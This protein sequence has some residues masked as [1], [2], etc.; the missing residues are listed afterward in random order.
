M[1]IHWPTMDEASSRF[2]NTFFAGLTAIGLIAGGLYTLWQYLTQYKLQVTVATQSARVP[3]DSKRLDL[4]LQAS[5]DA[6][7]IAT[8]SD[9]KAKEQAIE[10][11]WRL[12][13]GPLGIV[14]DQ[15]IAA[16]LT[17]F[18]NCLKEPCK[19]QPLTTLAYAIAQKCRTAVSK[20]FSLS[21]HEVPEGRSQS[22]YNAA[23]R[24]E[25]EDQQ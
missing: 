22:R 7:S 14:E 25:E 10:D 19:T 20:S 2:W 1:N 11:F 8:A 3:F 15:D 16:A 12:Y 6:A 9:S 24:H 4:C 13:W 21:L 18:G 23:S 17:Q 5:A